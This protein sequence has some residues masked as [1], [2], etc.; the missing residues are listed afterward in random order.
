MTVAGDSYKDRW[1][2]QFT[3]VSVDSPELS[4]DGH[5]KKKCSSLALSTE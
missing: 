4:T 2:S 1:I 5:V 3:N